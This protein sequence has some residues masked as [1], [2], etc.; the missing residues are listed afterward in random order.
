MS[1]TVK[2]KLEKS[3]IGHKG[4]VSELV[5][6][7]PT[8]SDY[9]SIGECFVWVPRGDGYL[10][11]SPIHE[12]LRKYTE[13]CLVGVDA[14]MLDQVGLKDGKKIADAF[15]GFFRNAEPGTAASSTSSGSSPDNTGGALATSET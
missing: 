10:V 4:V 3:L 15:I 13:R 7:E 2:I 8:F 14:A 6:K 12:N 1:E 9:T 5:F 11:A